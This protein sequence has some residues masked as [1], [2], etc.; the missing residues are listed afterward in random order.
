[1]EAAEKLLE[2][3]TLSNLRRELLTPLKS[4]INVTK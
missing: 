4:I 2:R 1:M 3:T